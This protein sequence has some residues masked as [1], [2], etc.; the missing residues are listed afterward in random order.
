[1][2]DAIAKGYEMT[3]QCVLVVKDHSEAIKS[4]Q[5]D[6]KQ[7]G[8][9]IQSNW[10]EILLA[11]LGDQSKTLGNISWTL[12][13]SRAEANTSR[14]RLPPCPS[15]NWEHHK[16]IINGFKELAIIIYIYTMILN[17]LEIIVSVNV[18]LFLV[19]RHQVTRADLNIP[20]MQSSAK[21]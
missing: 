10:C 5:S 2:L 13:G 18:S 1:M 9:E 11:Q 19:P 14:R 15:S 20:S 8:E 6:L 7:V 4:G 16:E 3:K 21:R 12:N 17:F